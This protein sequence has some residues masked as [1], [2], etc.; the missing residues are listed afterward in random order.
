MAGVS[1][2]SL[3]KGAISFGLVRIP[4]ALHSAVEDTRPKMRMF[5]VGGTSGASDE[6]DSA[7]ESAPLA[8]IGHQNVNKETGEAVPP[9][10]VAKGLEVEPGQFVLPSKDEIREALP[11]TT[12]LIELEAFVKVEEVPTAF[13]SKPYYV[14]PLGRG[15]KAYALLR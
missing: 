13:Y 6:A 12:Q 8:A 9:E 1:T 10:R 4:I 11:K 14:S 3:W 7:A 2:R 15:Q 5:D